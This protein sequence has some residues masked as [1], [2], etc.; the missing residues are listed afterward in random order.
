MLGFFLLLDVLRCFEELFETWG[1]EEG[2]ARKH[3][4]FAPRPGDAEAE[5]ALGDTGA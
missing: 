2:A 4:V 1:N 5:L 3:F